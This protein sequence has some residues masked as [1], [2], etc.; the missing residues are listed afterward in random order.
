MGNWFLTASQRTRAYLGEEEDED[1][2]GGEAEYVSTRLLTADKPCW[3]YQVEDEDEEEEKEYIN[4]LS[5]VSN[6]PSTQTP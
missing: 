3:S 6:T 2:E 1:E 5:L 4:T